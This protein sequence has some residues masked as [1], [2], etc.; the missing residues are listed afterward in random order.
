MDTVPEITDQIRFI[1]IDKIDVPPQVR[2]GFEAGRIDEMAASLKEVGQQQP[3]L[4]RAMDERYELI[5]GERRL[6]AAGQLGWLT[7]KAIVSARELSAGEILQI[8]LIENLQRVDLCPI[9]T[10]HGIQRYME[11]DGL[12]A[13]AVAKRLG[14]SPGAV[15]KLLG[16]LKLPA[17]IQQQVACGKI[18]ASAAYELSRVDDDEQRTELAEGLA[19]GRMTRDE[20]AGTLK[21][22]R[23]AKPNS[24]PA[25][26]RVTAALSGGRT[27][28]VM[29]PTVTLEGFIAILDELLSKARR[30]R[31]KGRQIDTFLSSLRDEALQ[32][33]LAPVQ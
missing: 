1:A 12:K 28:T 22:T 13:G 27:V 31:A 15:S 23:I 10:A 2:T 19:T 5:F 3:I 32:P 30:E 4:V 6:R 33:L 17:E 26:G 21:A 8:Q 14:L 9:E 25:F 11:V 18:A 7:I 20:L 24:R 29:G 16:L